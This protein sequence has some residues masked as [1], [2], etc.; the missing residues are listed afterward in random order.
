MKIINVQKQLIASTQK[1]R[2]TFIP[3]QVIFIKLTKEFPV[4]IRVAGNVVKR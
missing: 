2:M 3:Y 4:V 1:L